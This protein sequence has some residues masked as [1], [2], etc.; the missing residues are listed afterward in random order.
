MKGYRQF[1]P[2]AKAAEI[3]TERWTPLIVRELLCGSRRFNDL[4]RGVPLMSP[5]LLSKRLKSLESAGI[6]ERRSP[7]GSSEYQLTPAGEELR[8]IVETLGVWG[9]RWA[10]RELTREDLDAGLLM[11]DVH[12]G[13]AAD[14]LPQG[15][16][17]IHFELT[18]AP[19]AK[20]RWWLVAND[21]DVELCLSDPGHDVDLYVITD[22]KT[23]TQ[24]WMGDIKVDRAVANE[25]IELH[26]SP[27]LARR[28]GSWLGRSFFAGV[29]RPRHR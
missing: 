16:T 18:D 7:G 19:R 27:Q 9:Q 17:V 29:E 8:P 5:A 15:R 6:I 20:R 25:L 13:L 22:V 10:R 4:R 1:C 3:L 14:R 12:R 23:M 2:V 24:V 26:G 11:W 21:G 28:I